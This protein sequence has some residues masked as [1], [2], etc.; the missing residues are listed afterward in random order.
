MINSL[1]KAVT[2]IRTATGAKPANLHLCATCFE[3]VQDEVHRKAKVARGVIRL[4]GLNIVRFKGCI[5]HG[6]RPEETE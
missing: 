2:D 1:Q 5:I 6:E 3:Q 4:F